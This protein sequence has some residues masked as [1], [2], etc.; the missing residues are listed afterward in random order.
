MPWGN[1][2]EFI[3]SVTFVGAVAWLGRADRR[4][5]IRH[6][7]LFVTLAW[8]CC[9]AADGLIA[10]TPVGPLVPALQLV[11]VR[12]PRLD[13]HPR[14]PASCCS[15]RC[16]PR[17]S[18]SRPA[19]TRASGGSRT[20]SGKQ[21]PG[22]GDAGAADLP[23]ARLRVPAV[24]VRR[25]DRRAAVGRGVLGPVL[26]LGPQGGLG[27][28]L[29]DRLRLLPARPGHPER[30]AH[31]GHVDRAARLRDDADEPVRREPFLRGPALLRQRR[32]SPRFRG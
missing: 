29:L 18:S 24:H 31:H 9:S 22:R 4:P 13:D 14:R 11:L 21:L 23:A 28:H 12:H 3:L 20:R 32:L 25:A 8:S 19:T 1:M 15:A 10:Y 30:Q 6:L 2:Y 26:G 27:V 16:R 7:G 5:A 17:C